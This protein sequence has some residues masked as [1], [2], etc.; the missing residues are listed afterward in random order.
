MRQ[1]QPRLGAWRGERVEGLAE[2]EQ[3]LAIAIFT[4]L[5][6]AEGN[7]EF[8]SLVHDAIDESI[9]AARLLVSR[10]VRRV[11][12]RWVP[13]VVIISV[14][15]EQSATGQLVLDLK[16]RPRD[17]D[18]A[19][20]QL[21]RVIESERP[22]DVTPGI[23]P[24]FSALPSISGSVL[25]DSLLTCDPGE[26]SGTDPLFVTYQWR[27]DGV[28]IVGATTATHVVVLADL[29][30]LPDIDCLVTVQNS[31]AVVS[32]AAPP[33][34]HVPVVPSFT[35]DP[36][37]TGSFLLGETLTCVPGTWTGTEP[38]AV[39]YQWRRSDTPIS[40]A[41]SA[42]YEVVSL[43]M[44]A[45]LT[46]EVT[47]TSMAGA[48]V[49]VTPERFSDATPPVF[50]VSPS[51]SGTYAIG[52]TLT[53]TPGTWTGTAPITVTYQWRRGGVAISGATSAT[54][55]VASLDYVDGTVLT[56]LVTL[57][58]AVA[59]NSELSNALTCPTDPL[60]IFGSALVTWFEPT[61]IVVSG[62]VVNSWLDR[63]GNAR[64]LTAAGALTRQV[65]LID[66]HDAVLS[67]VAVMSVALPAITWPGVTVATVTRHQA[68]GAATGTVV[69]SKPGDSDFSSATSW[70]LGS[71][72]VSTQA[73]FYRGGSVITTEGL[74][75]VTVRIS[76]LD[77]SLK[78]V[79]TSE[80][81]DVS[82]A[83]SY[84]GLAPTFLGVFARHTGVLSGAAGQWIAASEIVVAAASATSGQYAALDGYFR[85]K[86]P[87]LY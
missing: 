38:I 70:L 77:A 41:T 4:P 36:S 11:V 51:I 82:S 61:G 29:T 35:V 64:N 50:T 30:G 7:P 72:A 84:T 3:Q 54:Y 46:C 66:G 78:R 43:D 56:C 85:A 33:V 75:S 60:S 2:L 6:S 27:R 17:S 71:N 81:A 39:T 16:W 14:G 68:G 74:P 57:T 31:I 18:V 79:R 67:T 59:S 32:E 65:G 21:T 5:G 83:S 22:A 23:A 34:V 15:A 42:T 25:L 1:W 10:E 44:S 28:A 8:G 58:N 9:V 24:T 69:L 86:Y 45:P 55:V 73:D 52:E 87:G 53:C 13:R 49:A 80:G 26:Y 40:G 12:K 37:I 63:S 76:T 48:D 20:Q 47:A 19:T 62:G